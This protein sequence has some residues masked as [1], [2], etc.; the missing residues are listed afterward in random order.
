MTP[1]A[2][3]SVAFALV[4]CDAVS[5]PVGDDAALV[6]SS[7]ASCWFVPLFWL[8]LLL[9]AFALALVSSVPSFAA[10]PPIAVSFS[11]GLSTVVSLAPFTTVMLTFVSTA[12]LTV[13]SVGLRLTSDFA[14]STIAFACLMVDRS[15]ALRALALNSALP[16]M[17]TTAIVS[18]MTDP[19]ATLR[20]TSPFVTGAIIG[21]PSSMPSCRNRLAL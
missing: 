21:L 20:L 12:L 16:S 14:C 1:C 19:A 5:A 6:G 10:P 7:F 2:F 18:V 9:A 17:M 3:E 15:S 11:V 13:A 8:T 4:P